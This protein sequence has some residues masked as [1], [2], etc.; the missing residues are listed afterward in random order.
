MHP[1]RATDKKVLQAQMKNYW[2]CRA[3][4]RWGIG[5]QQRKMEYTCQTGAFPR[6]WSCDH[7]R[8]VAA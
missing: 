2:L 8:D 5:A 1:Q 3:F 6:R 4:G 7:D